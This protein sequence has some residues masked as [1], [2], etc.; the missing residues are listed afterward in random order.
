MEPISDLETF[1]ISDTG[2]LEWFWAQNV[3]LE[4]FTTQLTA[5]MAPVNW[6]KSSTPANYGKKTNKQK[7]MSYDMHVG[8]ILHNGT[9]M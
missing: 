8:L 1:L 4:P 7:N 5:H 2:Y 3:W 6:G 9:T